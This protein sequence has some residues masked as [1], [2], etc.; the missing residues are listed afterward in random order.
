MINLRAT[1]AAFKQQS[2]HFFA[3]PQWVIPSLIAP[4]VFTIVTIMLFKDVDGPVVLYAVLGG[5]VLG[6]W[7]NTLYSSGW[8]INYDRMN[9]TIEPLL[10]SPTPIIQVVAGRAIWNSLIGLANALIVFLIAEI[11]FDVQVSISDP[12]LFFIAL[13]LTLLS[14]SAI[15][16]M[17]SAFFVLTRSST[18]LMQ[19]LEFPIYIASGAMVPLSVMP[20]WITPFSY[21]L[22]PSWGV[23]A[24]RLSGLPG[25]H[26]LGFDYLGDILIMCA[27]TFGY[28]LLS[29]VL[30]RSL[31][32]K[33]RIYGTLGR[34]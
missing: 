27:L 22:G 10:I 21:I 12:L 29:L 13:V 20:G 23:D 19:T 11:A 6:M 30:F 24:L 2:L 32:R 17:F 4:F 31:E 25:Y 3:D 15:G 14:L 1:A 34:Y 33:A 18:V 5:G 9:G 7:G 8:S 16:L 26:T 28:L